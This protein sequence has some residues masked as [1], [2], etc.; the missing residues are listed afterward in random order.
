[1]KRIAILTALIF[2]LLCSAQERPGI[3]LVRARTEL[4]VSYVAFWTWTAPSGGAPAV[5]YNLY[6]AAGAC[7]ATGLPAGT[8]IAQ[9]DPSTSF[10]QTPAPAG[11]TC[12]WV[13][14]VSAVGVEGLPSL[15]FQLDLDAPGA[16]GRPTPT[17]TTGA[18]SPQIK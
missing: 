14:G 6:Q 3:R 2:S 11:T 10:T 13:T 8:L 17:V 4:A 16:P 18:S 1:M 12:T 9:G 15:P 5:A 7:P